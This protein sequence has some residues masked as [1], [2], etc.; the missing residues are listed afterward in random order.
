M[1]YEQNGNRWIFFHDLYGQWQWLLTDAAGQTLEQAPCGH[2]SFCACA[3]NAAK[4]GFSVTSARAARL[5][6]A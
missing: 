3:R 5:R 4:R 1:V 2:R 6:R